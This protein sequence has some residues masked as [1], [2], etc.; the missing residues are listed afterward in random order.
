[1]KTQGRRVG[2]I[3]GN[4]NIYMESDKWKGKKQEMK[5]NIGEIKEKKE[6]HERSYKWN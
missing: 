3:A 5:E 1:M 4:G 2:G 6:I